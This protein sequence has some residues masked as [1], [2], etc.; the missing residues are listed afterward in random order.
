VAP[1]THSNHKIRIIERCPFLVKTEQG[2]AMTN[3]KA[4]MIE[5]T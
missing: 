5:L 1:D 3:G 4:A 2:A